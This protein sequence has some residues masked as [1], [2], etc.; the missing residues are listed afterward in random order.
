MNKRFFIAWVAAFVVWM[1]GSF[2]VHGL[3]LHPEYLQLPKL[4]RSDA[5]SQQYFPLMILAHVV[6]AAAFVWIYARGAEAKPWL[7]QGLRYGVAV[8][9]LTVVPT[10]VIYLAVQPMPAALVAKQIVF[11]GIVLLLLGAVVAFVYRDRPHA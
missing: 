9:L 3:L 1:A 10:Y 6:M 8:A 7:G 11:D 2:V 5:D 4:F